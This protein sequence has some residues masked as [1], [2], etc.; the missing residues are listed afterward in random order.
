MYLVTV[1]IELC[2]TVAVVHFVVAIV[3]V[4]L[5]V[6]VVRAGLMPRAFEQYLEAQARFSKPGRRS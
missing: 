1:E 6:S 2:V 4:L 5:T 3:L